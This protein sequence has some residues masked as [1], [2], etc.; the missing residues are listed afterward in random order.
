MKI[1][2]AE[3]LI[4][5]KRIQLAEKADEIQGIIDD[6]KQGLEVI[7]SELRMLDSI[8]EQIEADR[9]TGNG[10]DADNNANPTD[11]PPGSLV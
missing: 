5:E 4:R 11:P 6:Q 1:S 7:D 10:K 8:I 3:Q 9:K 2:R